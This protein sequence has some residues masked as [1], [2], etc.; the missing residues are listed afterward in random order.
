M[1]S[2]AGQAALATAT[3]VWAAGCARQPERPAEPAA[4]VA[5]APVAPEPAPPP[6]APSPELFAGL[7][8]EWARA[9][10]ERD[11][12][13]LERLLAPEFLITGVGSTVEDPVGGR[14]EWLANVGKYPWPRHQV[15]DL[16]LAAAGETAVVK[17]VWTG[18]YPPQSLTAEGGV[19]Q[20]LVT[21][22][23]IR[24]G[25]EWV[26]LARHTSLPRQESP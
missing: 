15:S 17:C 13:T 18:T 19:L 22:V 4:A 5:P 24:R 12:T 6:A 2:A 9:L 23:W 11:G 21:D 14:D 10:T 1:R 8:A 7:E 20:M 3:L 25:G 26:V 16:R